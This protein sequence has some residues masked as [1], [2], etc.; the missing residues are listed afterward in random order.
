MKN[1]SET[2]TPLFKYSGASG[3]ILLICINKMD[4]YFHNNHAIFNPFLEDDEYL[5]DIFIC[6]F[7]AP[8]A[9]ALLTVYF[10]LAFI[11][12]LFEIPFCF[13]SSIF[14]A[15]KKPLTSFF[16]AFV[17]AI[18][19]PISFVINF[20]NFF[21]AVTVLLYNDRKSGAQVTKTAVQ[22]DT[23][24]KETAVQND[25]NEKETDKL[26][27]TKWEITDTPSD[28]TL[29]Y[30]SLKDVGEIISE[31]SEVLLSHTLEVFSWLLETDTGDSTQRPIEQQY[32]LAT[33]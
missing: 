14:D 11:V 3:K 16:V 27:N 22:N 5:L 19:A 33:A 24:E 32:I 8:V 4:H 31:I 2:V 13:T 18:L 15:L 29:I 12:E 25:T 21:V 9:Q 1:S 6:A 20:Y 10:L 30:E 23:N 17:S 7:T 26:S 28:I